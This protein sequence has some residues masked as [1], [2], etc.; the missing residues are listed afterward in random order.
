MPVRLAVEPGYDELCLVACKYFVTR[1]LTFRP[2]NGRLGYAEGRTEESCI[3]LSSLGAEV[4]VHFGT[5]F[6]G[7]ER[8]S[9]GE[10]MVLPAALGSYRIEGTGRLLLSYVP[11]PDDKAW[12]LWEAKNAVKGT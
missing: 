12:R 5:S 9:R 6:T 1:E 3:I 11:T 8:L 2:E 7:S 4:E 10:T